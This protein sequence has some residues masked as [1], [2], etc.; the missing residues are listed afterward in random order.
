MAKKIQ[1]DNALRY[2][3]IIMIVSLILMLLFTVESCFVG[4]DICL[5][6]MLRLI[7]DAVLASSFLTLSCPE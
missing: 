2:D 1:H 4:S 5:G 7:Y 6:F 3:M